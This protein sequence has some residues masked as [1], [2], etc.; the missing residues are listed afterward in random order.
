MRQPDT[1]ARDRR[2]PR[3]RAAT[4]RAG[5]P[6]P[7]RPA[8]SRRRRPAAP[9]SRRCRPVST[10][11]RKLPVLHYGRVPVFDPQTW[12]LR[13]FGAT[14][15]PG[16]DHAWSWRRVR[17]A[18]APRGGRRLPLRDQVHH[19]RRRWD[20]HPGGRAAAAVPPAAAVTHVM[21][22]ADFGYSANVRIT[23]FAADDTLLATHRDGEPLTP[24][25]GYPL[26]LVVPGLYA[27]K[28]VKWVRADRV[29][30]LRPAGLLG[31]ARLPQ[32]R[33]PVARAAL[34]LPGAATARARRCDAATAA[35][36]NPQA[37][38]PAGNL[39]RTS[40]SRR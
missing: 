25:H 2:G 8:G 21:I 14:A 26:R 36:A 9:R 15:S 13:I 11:P 28:S 1:G 20:G 5:R 33:R 16:R 17:Q 35:A 4:G 18:A 3:P 40:R 22:W 39:R 34:L 12:D 38:D 37:E 7:D 19:P 27:W 23:D 32:H 29:P 6:A 30:D 31:G 10:C 24:E